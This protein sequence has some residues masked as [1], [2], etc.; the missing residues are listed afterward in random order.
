MWR[1]SRRIKSINSFHNMSLLKK[2]LL[3]VFFRVDDQ[4]EV[5]PL[6]SELLNPIQRVIFSPE[7]S[8]YW[9]SLSPQSHA[10]WYCSFL[11]IALPLSRNPKGLPSS[12]N[13]RFKWVSILLYSDGYMGYCTIGMKYNLSYPY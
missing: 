9:H 12:T 2:N 13:S 7:L 8:S 5:C 3:Y 4:V 6:S 11:S 10:L 1:N